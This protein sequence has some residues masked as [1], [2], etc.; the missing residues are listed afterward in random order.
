MPSRKA[1]KSEIEKN[2]KNQKLR[3]TL[4][5]AARRSGKTVKQE[6]KVSKSPKKNTGRLKRS[7]KKIAT[8]NKSRY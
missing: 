7:Q 4:R 5:K 2:K 6:G 8:I 1:T 3:N